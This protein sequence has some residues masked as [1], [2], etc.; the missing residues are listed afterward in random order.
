M[1]R[2]HSR[3]TGFGRLQS[4]FAGLAAFLLVSGAAGAQTPPS[5]LGGDTPGVT[6]DRGSTTWSGSPSDLVASLSG[7]QPIERVTNLEA[8]PL[9]IGPNSV[10]RFSPDG[11]EALIMLAWYDDP[12]GYG[13]D[14]FLVTM[15]N[16]HENWRIV[17]L[18]KQD[19]APAEATIRDKPKGGED[20]V[21]SVRFA[22]G[23][24]DGDDATFLLIATRNDRDG[25]GA[26]DTAYEVFRLA[27]LDGRDVFERVSRRTLPVQYCNADMALTV[28]SGLPL[29]T[30]YRGRRD[31]DGSFTRDGCE[32]T[33]TSVEASARSEAAA[34][35]AMSDAQKDR[36]FRQF[37]RWDRNSSSVR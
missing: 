23:K 18:L 24:L 30:S 3:Q 1:T 2:H 27:Q 36:L 32:G 34:G 15:P 35:D 22:R 9:Q 7:A 8:I 12:A 31:P 26:S 20:V 14:V 17:G 21:R 37:L 28:A 4:G 25:P 6:S 19:A 11:R 16:Q 5:G 33:G 29:R 10:P 13:H